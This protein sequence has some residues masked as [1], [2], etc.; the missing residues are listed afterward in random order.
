MCMFVGLP[1]GYT[2]CQGPRALSESDT[3]SVQV[4]PAD[5][6]QANDQYERNNTPT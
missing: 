6:D 4:R 1:V 5:G 2:Q 3:M